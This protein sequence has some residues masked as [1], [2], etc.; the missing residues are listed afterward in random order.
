LPGFKGAIRAASISEIPEKVQALCDRRKRKIPD[1]PEDLEAFAGA[2]E[3][4]GG[5]WFWMLIDVDE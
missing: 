3:L 2:S 4:N 1:P 5:W